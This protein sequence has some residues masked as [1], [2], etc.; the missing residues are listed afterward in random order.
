MC[1]IALRV[2]TYD[3]NPLTVMG[4]RFDSFFPLSRSCCLATLSDLS[5]SKASMY[6][7]YACPCVASLAFGDSYVNFEV[8]NPTTQQEEKSTLRACIAV[9]HPPSVTKMRLSS[10]CIV[11]VSSIGD[12]IRVR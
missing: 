3:K 7:P 9:L 1:R 12:P 6:R 5:R 8:A 2:I 11:Q 10:L 4:I